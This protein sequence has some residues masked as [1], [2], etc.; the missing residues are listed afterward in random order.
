MLDFLGEL[1][2]E[3]VPTYLGRAT[4]Y[5]LNHGKV[6]WKT[7]GKDEGKNW[8]YGIGVILGTFFLGI[9]LY[10]LLN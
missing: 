2:R 9:Q 1:I 3:F 7:L 8:N 6:G 10:Q 4:R 5:I